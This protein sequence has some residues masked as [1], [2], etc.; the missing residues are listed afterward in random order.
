MQSIPLSKNVDEFVPKER[1][2]VSLSNGETIYDD[3]RPG[4]I[5][6][7]ER[8]G[9]YC[10][11]NDLSITKL[12]MRIK[13][14]E[15]KLPSNQDG[16]FQKKVAWA[17]MNASGQRLCIGYIQGNHC[18]TYEVD[19]SGDSRTIRPGHPDYQGPPP[20]PWSIYKRELRNA[21]AN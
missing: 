7:W 17:T 15:I 14:V 4:I 8:L 13:G 18:L 5:P 21:V 19:S 3:R 9:Q 12:R 6:A 1:W 11:E 10:L 20:F 2:V 16:Y